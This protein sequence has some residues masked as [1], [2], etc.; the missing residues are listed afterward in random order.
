MMKYQTIY[1]ITAAQIDAS[2]RLTIDG[3]LTFYENTVARYFTLLGLAAF[4]LQK[5]D[6]TWVITEIN[7]E[8]P[9]PPAMWSEDVEM[10]VWIS[11]MTPLRVWVEFVAREV[12]SGKVSAKGNGCWSLISMSERKLV[13]CG[14]LITE[15]ECVEEFAAGPHRRRGVV[16]HSEELIAT[17]KHT[18]NRIDLDFNG[19][20]NNRRYVQMALSC[21]EE[22]YLSEQR[23]DFLNIRFIRESLIGDEIK[24]LSHP[25]D[26]PALFVS[27]ILNS[28]GEEICHAITHW[29]EKEAVQD[30][31]DVNLVR[32]PALKSSQF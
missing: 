12:H 11:E 8:Q 14:G 4:D 21:F 25:T 30:I 15:S 32:N 10:T 5:E 24:T 26:D 18:V 17:L 1:P 28:R 16:K 13:P 31:S 29:R 22:S 7:I 19:H 27:R 20:T 3:V 23:P 9:E 2:Y 6:K